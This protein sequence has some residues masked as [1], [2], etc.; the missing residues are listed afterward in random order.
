MN[1]DSVRRSLRFVGKTLSIR[2]HVPKR[3]LSWIKAQNLEETRDKCQKYSKFAPQICRTFILPTGEF[4][5]G[6]LASRAAARMLAQE[7][8]RPRKPPRA[9]IKVTD[10]N[11]W[12]TICKHGE[13]E[14][15][16][17]YYIQFVWA[18]HETAAE[19]ESAR[20]ELLAQAS[21][22]TGSFSKGHGRQL[23]RAEFM[24]AFSNPG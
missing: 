13:R 23:K 22:E 14:A 20:V 17:D 1:S 3:R 10:L 5:I 21:E 12:L 18:G 15:K 2:F 24:K 16:T 7:K 6:S 4:P 8:R 19:I 11:Q 9:I